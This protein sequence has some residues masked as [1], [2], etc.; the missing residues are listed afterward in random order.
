MSHSPSP[1]LSVPPQAKRIRLSDSFVDNDKDKEY[2]KQRLHRIVREGQYESSFFSLVEKGSELFV[3]CESCDK[4][5]ATGDK[6]RALGG[7][8]RHLTGPTHKIKYSKKL[9]EL[10]RKKLNETKEATNLEQKIQQE[11]ERKLW[12]EALR[13]KADCI[14]LRHGDCFTLLINANSLMC[15]YCMKRISLDGAYEHNAAEHVKSSDHIDNKTLG[16]P[17]SSIKSYFTKPL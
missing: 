2:F 11:K 1:N 6:H 17:Q 9:D 12:G 13:K 16:K 7:F 10:A 5:V 8:S 4:L 15:K 14:N 3:H